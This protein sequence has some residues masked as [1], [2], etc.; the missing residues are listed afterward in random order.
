VA[1][2]E[3]AFDSGIEMRQRI[4][5]RHHHTQRWRAPGGAGSDRHSNSRL[6]NRD[7]SG[8][9]LLVEQVLAPV[10]K[11]VRPCKALHFR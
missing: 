3:D 6:V 9:S 4:V 11:R 7:L 8:E 1:L 5:H 10:P 2:P